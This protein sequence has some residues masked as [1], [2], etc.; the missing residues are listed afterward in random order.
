MAGLKEGATDLWD[1][2]DDEEADD[3]TETATST[4]AAS[5]TERSETA[6]E[7][8]PGIPYVKKRRM[9]EEKTTWKRERVT[10]YVR[11]EVASGERSLIAKAEEEFDRDIPKF[12]IREAAYIAAQE[13]PELVY[14]QLDEMGYE[15]D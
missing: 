15:R 11:D 14:E 7:A 5:D 12:D 9:E 2:E 4:Q 13:N 3:R 8:Q 6:S 10:F 1:D